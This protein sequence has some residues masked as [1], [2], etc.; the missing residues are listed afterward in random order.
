MADI[1]INRQIDERYRKYALYVIESRGIPNWYD[2]LTNVQRILIDNC[3]SSFNKTLSV[4]G[5]AISAGYHSGDASLVSTINRLARPFNCAEQIMIGDGFF[6]CPVSPNAASARYTSVKLNPKIKIILEKYYHLNRKNEEELYDNLV[7]DMPFGLSAGV[8][9]IAVG[10]KSTILPRKLEHIQDFFAGKRKHVE[11]YFKDFTGTVKKHGDDRT[12]LIAGN[13]EVDDVARKILITSLPPL[14][15][16]ESFLKKM[17]SILEGV[18]FDFVNNS[19]DTVDVSVT[20]S[21]REDD[22]VWQ[23]VKA[24]IKKATMMIVHESVVFIRNKTVIEYERLEDYLLDFADETERTKLF[25][26]EWTRIKESSELV[27][28]KAKL[29][30][31]KFMVVKKRTD[32]EITQFLSKFERPIT[33]RLDSIKLRQLSNEE[34]ERTVELIAIQ[35]QNIKEILQAEKQQEKLVNSMKF[36]LRG[37]RIKPAEQ[38]FEHQE[39]DGIEVFD[40]QELD[41]ETEV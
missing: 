41:E 20:I 39:I 34:V 21:R 12:W 2:S 40:L 13:V 16:F 37:K 3:P 4:V 38:L 23:E 26:L 7:V 11:P 29:E 15:K 6:G 33:S 31:L 8:M 5:S 1:T 25:H 10:Y 22:E 32:D 36:E 9:G 18:D 14:I 17:S 35:E 19:S 27:F 28:L 24:S 30:Y